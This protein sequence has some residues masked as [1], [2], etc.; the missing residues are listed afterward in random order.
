MKK[1]LRILTIDSLKDLLRY[2]SFFLLIFLLLFA[3]RVIHRVVKPHEG[4]FVIPDGLRLSA[5]AARHV[6]TQLPAELASR[7]FSPQVR[8]G[9]RRVVSIETGYFPLA[10]L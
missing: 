6:F 5:E 10:L 4:G 9:C 7:V 8:T 1:L 3:D 2:K